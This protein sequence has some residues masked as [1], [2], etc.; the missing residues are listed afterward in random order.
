MFIQRSKKHLVISY[1]VT[2]SPIFL[3]QDSGGFRTFPFPS[4]T[5]G[6]GFRPDDCPRYQQ[7]EPLFRPYLGLPICETG[8]QR[9]FTEAT[10]R[11][12]S[13]ETF[14]LEFPQTTTSGLLGRRVPCLVPLL[15]LI[16]PFVLC[17]SY[18]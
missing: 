10:L 9:T 12:S 18:R 14:S 13:W 17:K 15:P 16:P 3:D 8:V 4:P 6:C 2:G 7:P 11:H 5:N 1:L